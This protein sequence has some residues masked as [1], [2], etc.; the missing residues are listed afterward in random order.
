MRSRKENKEPHEAKKILHSINRVNELFILCREKIKARNCLKL[1]RLYFVWV[2][3]RVDSFQWFVDLSRS[4]H[5]EVNMV[6]CG[7][8][9]C[10]HTKRV[11]DNHYAE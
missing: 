5:A 4:T 8:S 2:C 3:K 6:A 9:C 1:R 7:S 10:F 11:S